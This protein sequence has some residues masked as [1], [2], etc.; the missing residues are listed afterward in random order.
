MYVYV[1]VYEYYYSTSFKQKENG[2]DVVVCDV[3]SKE[4]LAKAMQTSYIYIYI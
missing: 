4:E 3:L 1:Y 2:L